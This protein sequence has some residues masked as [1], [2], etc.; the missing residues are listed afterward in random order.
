MLSS[1]PK[2]SLSVDIETKHFVGEEDGA[3]DGIIDGVSDGMT[4]NVGLDDN[5]GAPE[6]M[7]EVVGT[8]DSDGASVDKT[9]GNPDGASE[10]MVEGLIDKD[11][12]S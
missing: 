4:D 12:D 8:T 2:Q 3:T 7:T 5:D 6:G 1:L 9:E 10:R 11:A